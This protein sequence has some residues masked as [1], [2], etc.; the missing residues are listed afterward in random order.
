VYYDLRSD[1]YTFTDKKIVGKPKDDATYKKV[2]DD[3]LPSYTTQEVEARQEGG[4]PDTKD[5]AVQ[6]VQP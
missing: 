6:E 2:T 4:F 1:T 5:T 3:T